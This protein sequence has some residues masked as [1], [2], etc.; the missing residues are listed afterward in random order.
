M[1]LSAKGRKAI[2]KAVKAMWK[3]KKRQQEL[4]K[5]LENGELAAKFKP[6]A[7]FDEEVAAFIFRYG[8]KSLYQQ[9]SKELIK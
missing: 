1:P 5:Q 6:G 8:L 4:V 9:L 3:R 7:P 2:S